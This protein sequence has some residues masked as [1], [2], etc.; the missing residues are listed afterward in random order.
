MLRVSWHR[1]MV[2]R[3]QL[4]FHVSM[5]SKQAWHFLLAIETAHPIECVCCFVLLN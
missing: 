5:Q 4:A 1:Y 3:T 2:Q